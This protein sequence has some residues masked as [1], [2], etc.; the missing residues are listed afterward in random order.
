MFEVLATGGDTALGGDDF[1]H[2]LADWIAAQA[3]YQPQNANEQREL[4]TLATKTK[5]ALS[6]AVETEVKFANWTGTVSRSQ[7]NDLIQP[8]VKR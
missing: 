6:Q 1:D 7:F 3:D 5:V 2:L 8:L 4:L